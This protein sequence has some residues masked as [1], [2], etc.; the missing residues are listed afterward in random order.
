MSIRL[1]QGICVLLRFTFFAAFFFLSASA[2]AFAQAGKAELTG[3]AR[4]QAGAAVARATITVKRVGTGDVASATT[5]ADGVYTITNLPPGIY[6]V[7]AGA[8]CT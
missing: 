6:T 3:E 4:D 5:G 7:T 2:S 1:S 8:P